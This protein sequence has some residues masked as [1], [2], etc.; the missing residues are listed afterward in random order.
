M[1]ANVNMDMAGLAPGKV[2]V[3]GCWHM[4]IQRATKAI[5]SVV[6][7]LPD[8]EPRIILHTGDVGYF[9]GISGH[10]FLMALSQALADAGAVLIFV[11]G[12]HENHAALKEL[13]DAAKTLPVAIRRQVWW[14]PRGFRWRWHGFEWLALGGAVSVDQS[15]RTQGYDWWA[16]EEITDAD[17]A[18]AACGGHADVMIC[19]D[20][21]AGVPLAL[22]PPSPYWAPMHLLLSDL[23]RQRLRAVVDHVKPQVLMHG[24]YHLE[25]YAEVSTE[26]GVLRVTGLD[27]EAGKGAN[28]RVLD[29][30]TLAW[31]PGGVVV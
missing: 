20:C 23:H 9:P 26:W 10:M 4:S 11:D 24:H 16:E 19:H 18:F 2:V 21:P 17:A 25:H 27:R 8:E 13:A 31:E 14:M 5:R 15:G 7:L 30:R 12:N 6:E 22:P 1:K 3:A 29:T 28:L